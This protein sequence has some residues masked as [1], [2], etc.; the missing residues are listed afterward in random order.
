MSYF[1]NHMME[2]KK[3]H[4]I[5]VHCDIQVFE[6]LMNYISKKGNG[7]EFDNR[8]VVSLLISS[9]FLKMESLEKECLKFIHK[10]INQVI[11]VPI[12]LRCIPKQ[13][14]QS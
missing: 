10:N 2:N 4:E 8:S 1:S 6:W 7:M 5:D 14:L 13:A 12:D 11:Q 9:S 3:S